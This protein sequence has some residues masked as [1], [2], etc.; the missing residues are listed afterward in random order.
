MEYITA[1]QGDCQGFERGF[2][3]NF[4]TFSR[5]FARIVSYSAETTR[6]GNFIKNPCLLKAPIHYI[7]YIPFALSS[8][9]FLVLPP[10]WKGWRVSLASPFWGSF[11]IAG[12]GVTSFAHLIPHPAPHTLIPHT[13]R[14]AELLHGGAFARSKTTLLR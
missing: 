14:A 1:C 2:C 8:G 7:L 9:T 3:K 11:R 12:E 5:F 10:H 6:Y 13:K 4:L